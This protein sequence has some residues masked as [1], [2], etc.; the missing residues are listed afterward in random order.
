MHK[1]KHKILSECCLVQS[2]NSFLRCLRNPQYLSSHFLSL[3]RENSRENKRNEE[4]FVPLW[5]SKKNVLGD[6]VFASSRWQLG[7]LL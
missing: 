3:S 4:K 7:R 5:G 6:S 2:I 1:Y